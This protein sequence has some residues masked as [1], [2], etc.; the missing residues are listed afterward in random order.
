MLGLGQAQYV[1]RHFH[2]GGVPWVQQ[3]YA[4]L[5]TD[6]AF[7]PPLRVAVSEYQGDRWVAVPVTGPEDERM[8]RADYHIVHLHVDDAEEFIRRWKA[9]R[10]VK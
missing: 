5:A 8:R 1:A 10:K 9:E 6:P 7:G 4:N 3:G 2:Y